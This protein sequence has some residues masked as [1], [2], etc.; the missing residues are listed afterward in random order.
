M[1][2]QPSAHVFHEIVAAAW[3]H[4]VWSHYAVTV[5]HLRPT[6]GFP[7][8]VHY[9]EGSTHELMILAL[10]PA[11]NKTP[12]MGPN[13]TGQ[14]TFAHDSQGVALGQHIARLIKSRALNPDTDFLSSNSRTIEALA[15]NHFGATAAQTSWKEGCGPNP[16]GRA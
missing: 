3:A 12:L 5:V 1:A 16:V 14:F 10:D 7:A 13:Y 15:R 8:A 11:D 4:P 6:P 9:F 2:E